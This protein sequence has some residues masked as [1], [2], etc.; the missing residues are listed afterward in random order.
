MMKNKVVQRA[1]ARG[2]LKRYKSPVLSG[3]YGMHGASSLAAIVL[4]CSTSAL[5]QD[6]TVIEEVIVTAQR[7][8][9]NL[10]KVLIAAS[11][12]TD[13]MMEDRQIVGLADL[14]LRVPSLNYADQAFGR[15][16]FNIRGIGRQ[17]DQPGGEAGV[18][19]HLNSIPVPSETRIASCRV[20]S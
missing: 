18:S 9:E 10:Q 13:T 6:R 19:V 14:Q 2:G 1:V 7:V 17:N 11:A 15:G 8:E 5:A 4:V 20:H 16:R 12:F 3:R